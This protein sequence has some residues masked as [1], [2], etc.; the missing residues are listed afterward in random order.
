[1]Q[2]R[3]DSQ[4][5]WGI[6]QGVDTR[7]AAAMAGFQGCR[8]RAQVKQLRAGVLPW[9]LRAGS[10]G[11]PTLGLPTPLPLHSQ[12]LG[13]SHSLG[14]QLWRQHACR[15]RQGCPV[16]LHPLPQRIEAVP[17]QQGPGA[18]H[19]G[20]IAMQPH[21]KRKRSQGG[22][23]PR[24]RRR[25]QACCLTAPAAAAASKRRLCS[26][27]APAGGKAACRLA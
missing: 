24:G 23:Q 25:S 12:A 7:G 8:R 6:M 17:L 14:L 18:H 1:M 5:L 2:A 3:V 26:A 4:V 11:G 22:P 27:R 20:P 13:N 9:R 16:T 15:G 10:M 19:G 21:Q